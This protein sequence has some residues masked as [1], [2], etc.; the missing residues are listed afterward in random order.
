MS[1]LPPIDSYPELSPAYGRDYKSQSALK[2]DWNKGLDFKIES[3]GPH[4]GR[5][6]SIRDVAALKAAGAV[7]LNIRYK[8]MTM[9]CVIKL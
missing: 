3:I 4:C 8:R 1:N 5:M 6:T 9:V 7:A 2:A